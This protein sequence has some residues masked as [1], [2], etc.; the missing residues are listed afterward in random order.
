MSQMVEMTGTWAAGHIQ[1]LGRS[2][3]A[4]HVD[5]VSVL[6]MWFSNSTPPGAG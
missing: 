3:S 4:S 6:A 1:R 2:S 5:N